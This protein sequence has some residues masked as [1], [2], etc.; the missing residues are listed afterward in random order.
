MNDKHATRF[1]RS[2]RQGLLVYFI[3]YTKEPGEDTIS[4]RIPL[5]YSVLKEYAEVQRAP[6][7]SNTKFFLFNRILLLIK[8][9]RSIFRALK[10]REKI[11]IFGSD[12]PAGLIATV[13]GTLIKYMQKDKDVRVVYDSHGSRYKLS[14]DLNPPI[15]YK[16][17]N[18]FEDS[19]SIK[20]ADLII[21]P[22]YADKV[23]YAQYTRKKKDLVVLPSLVRTD[24]EYEKWS[25]R[26]L[27]LAFH[28]NF[29][30]P[31][32][33]ESLEI[34]S[35][36][37]ED[38]CG[39]N[40]VIFGINSQIA[41]KCIDPKVLKRNNIRILGYVDNP[42]LI[43]G[44]TKFYIAP[45]FKGTGIITKVLEAMAAGAVP[46]TTKFVALGIP[47]L[48]QWPELIALNTSDWIEKAEKHLARVYK[49]DYDAIS[50]K[51]TDIINKNYSYNTNKLLLRNVLEK[52]DC[53][54]RV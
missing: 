34:I 7:L 51:L 29:N 32:N 53:V 52:L 54:D 13:L 46:I 12:Q 15:I 26:K 19:L 18:I 36:W 35:R 24:M 16:V 42:Y 17:I 21:V 45:I 9:T 37:I 2:R 38:K 10:D 14:L 28:A 1:S 44:N 20:M 41:Y 27:D 50:K 22:T 30:Y 5:L 48:R 4:T 6:Q 8:S 43:L 31:P 23:I 33:I 25:T 11:I 47:E 49:L 3:P 39:I 40:L